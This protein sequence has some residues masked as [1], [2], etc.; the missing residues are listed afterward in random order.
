MWVLIDH[1][2]R[3]PDGR[4][5]RLR[6]PHLGDAAGDGALEVRRALRARVA[7]CALEWD[8]A[9]EVLVGSAHLTD[10]GEER[11]V[12]A[13]PAV[14]ALLHDALVERALSLRRVA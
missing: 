13:D 9:H 10:D 12:A 2:H 6:L 11:V 14:R 8:G 3:L 5:V 1:H 4:R 7:V